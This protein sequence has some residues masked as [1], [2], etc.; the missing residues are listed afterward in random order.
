MN[1]VEFIS[2]R[3]KAAKPKADSIWKRTKT[4]DSKEA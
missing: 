1:S 2:K 3:E 4:L